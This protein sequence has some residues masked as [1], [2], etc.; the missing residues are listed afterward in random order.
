MG[1]EGT[2][3]CRKA[4]GDAVSAFL[5]MVCGS[6]SRN[7]HGCASIYIQSVRVSASTNSLCQS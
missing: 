2:G 6:V 4:A 5:L 7:R 3:S 1:W